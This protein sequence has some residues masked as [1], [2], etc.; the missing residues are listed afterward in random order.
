MFFFGLLV[1]NSQKYC[2]ADLI[3]SVT[4][5]FSVSLFPPVETGSDNNLISFSKPRNSFKKQYGFVSV[6]ANLDLLQQVL[7][8]Y[9]LLTHPLR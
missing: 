7:L 8:F 3:S 4:F 1:Y 2:S 5:L 9:Y 6:S